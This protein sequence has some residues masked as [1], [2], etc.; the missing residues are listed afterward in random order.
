M[1]A[2]HYLNNKTSKLVQYTYTYMCMLT[3][4]RMSL[5]QV[6]LIL[7]SSTPLHIHGTLFKIHLLKYW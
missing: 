4:T 2:I 5:L 3:H 7:Q 6:L 1:T